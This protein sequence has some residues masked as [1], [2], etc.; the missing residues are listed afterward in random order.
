MNEVL[1]E[2]VE[3]KRR[4]HPYVGTLRRNGKGLQ[5]AGREVASGLEVSLTIPFAAIDD[6]RLASADEMG[7]I[8]VEFA[9]SEPIMLREVGN[10]QSGSQALVAK[11]KRALAAS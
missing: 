8:V 9:D 4:S 3:W 5:L 7:S 10:A 6:I 2:R 11:L 1:L